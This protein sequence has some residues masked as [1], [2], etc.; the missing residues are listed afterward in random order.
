MNTTAA[1]ALIAMLG[2]CVTE[3]TIGDGTPFPTE[4]GHTGLEPEDMPAFAGAGTPEP[5]ATADPDCGASEPICE[6]P[7]DLDL[8]TVASGSLRG[9]SGRSPSTGT[10]SRLRRT[11]HLFPPAFA[12]R[13]RWGIPLSASIRERSSNELS[14]GSAGHR[15][16][17]QGEIW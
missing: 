7:E 5:D 13:G 12:T 3:E 15:T 2:G 6:V 10:Y 14:S 4:T 1:I 9:R 11:L 8:S 17:T 16:F